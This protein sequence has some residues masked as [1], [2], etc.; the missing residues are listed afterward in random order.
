L[1]FGFGFLGFG[2]MWVV[3]VDYIVFWGLVGYDG[4]WC[5]VWCGV[6]VLLDC[7][8]IGDGSLLCRFVWVVMS[9]W[10]YLLPAYGLLFVG[11]VLWGWVFG[12]SWGF[13]LCVID[14]ISLGLVLCV[15]DCW[16]LVI[17]LYVY[18]L[19][20]IVVLCYCVAVGWLGFGVWVWVFGIW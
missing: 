4:V 11:L 18:L 15:C 17:C 9:V 7:L 6:V 16:L 5:L 14:V 20:V 1:G 13:G 2:E 12:L 8:D 3:G 10:W 19:G